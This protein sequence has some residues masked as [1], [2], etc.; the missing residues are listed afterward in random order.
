MTLGSLT[1]PVILGL[2]PRIH[3]CCG[4]SPDEAKT[5]MLGTRPSM[6]VGWAKGGA[7]VLTIVIARSGATKQSRVA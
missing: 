2:V 3:A 5:W 4:A 7:T 1:P 6:T